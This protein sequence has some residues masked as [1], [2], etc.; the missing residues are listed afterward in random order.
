MEILIWANNNPWIGYVAPI[1]LPLLALPIV[2]IL[3]E[4]MRVI[5]K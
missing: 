1:L 2:Y 3:G 5:K 4:V